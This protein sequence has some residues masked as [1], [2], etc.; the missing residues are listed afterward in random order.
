M[1]YSGPHLPESRWRTPRKKAT[2]EKA[3][4][5]KSTNEENNAKNCLICEMFY[6]M[7]WN[8]EELIL[9]RR[10][11]FLSGHDPTM[12]DNLSGHFDLLNPNH[13]NPNPR[14]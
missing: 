14:R 11:R 1:I 4:E 12:Y 13:T 5:N 2:E 10:R 6:F 3:T 8:I 7:F 9:T